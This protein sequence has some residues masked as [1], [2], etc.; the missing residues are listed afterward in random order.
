MSIRSVLQPLAK[1]DADPGALA[2]RPEQ[3][4]RLPLTT[5]EMMTWLQLAAGPGQGSLD[6]WLRGR[7]ARALLASGGPSDPDS[8]WL[9]LGSEAD[10]GRV[11]KALENAL[12]TPDRPQGA[13]ALLDAN[14]HWQSWR[15]DR[16]WPRLLEPIGPANLRGVLGAYVSWAP[17]LLVVAGLGVSWI[18]AIGAWLAIR[19]S[20]DRRQ[21]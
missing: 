7:K 8:L 18:V 19:A 3:P 20:R 2:E 9:V 1:Q 12:D 15:S 6:D 11:V 14:G 4:G 13:V 17:G 16:V 21:G 10:P 5:G